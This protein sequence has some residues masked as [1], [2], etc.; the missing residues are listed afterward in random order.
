MYPDTIAI[1]VLVGNREAAG[2]NIIS[3]KFKFSTFEA[4]LVL[5]RCVPKLGSRAIVNRSTTWIFF[6]Y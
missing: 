6:R 2:R 5:L 4:P 3:Y 1:F